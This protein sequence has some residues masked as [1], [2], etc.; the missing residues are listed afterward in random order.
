VLEAYD[1]VTKMIFPVLAAVAAIG[2]GTF[3]LVG[4]DKPEPQNIVA[5]TAEAQIVGTEF[6][7]L[8]HT[9]KRVTE[10]DYKGKYLLIYF[11]YTNCPE[12][13]PIN[14]ASISD[15][16]DKFGSLA[17]EIIPLFVTIDPKRDSVEQIAEYIPMFSDRIIGLTGTP[18]ELDQMAAG[19]RVFYEA[20]I[21]KERGEG[22]VDF[23]HS[24]LTFLVGRDGKYITHFPDGVEAETIVSTTKR[25]IKLFE[26][27]LLNPELT[28]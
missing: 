13:C 17:D 7:L 15:A 28:N 27:D 19:Y 20:Y 21:N 16:M 24:S 5:N 22:F 12:I 10:K 2:A 8:D 14:L 23:N 18:E 6:S 9:G 1:M 26:P 25:M 4:K 11:G 3:F